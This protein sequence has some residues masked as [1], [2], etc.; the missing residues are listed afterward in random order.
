M[1]ALGVSPLVAYYFN[2]VSLISPVANLI[3]TPLVGFLLVPLSLAG[4]FLYMLTGHFVLGPLVQL[5]SG[6][7]VFLVRAFADVPAASVAAGAFPVG[8][9][10]VFYTGFAL[11]WYG[12]KKYFIALAIVP[13]ALYVAVNVASPRPFAV[14]FLDVGEADASIVELPDNRV[15]VVDTG[16]TGYEVRDAL[17]YRGIRSIDALALT[18][19]H[20]DHSGGVGLLLEEFKVKELWDNGRL[21]YPAG[22]MEDI[23]HRRLVRGDVYRGPGYT[24]T[25]L[26]PYDGFYTA[27]GNKNTSINNDSMVLRIAGQEASFLFTGDI[28]A[29][30]LEDLRHLGAHLGSDVLKVS[31][32]GRE[33]SSHSV[34]FRAVSPRIAVISGI[35]AGSEIAGALGGMTIVPTGAHGA[36]KITAHDGIT[37]KAYSESLLK[38]TLDPREEARNIKRL[39]TVW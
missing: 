24:I 12:R 32:H 15:L 10:L 36:V 14:T 7:A 28:E 33:S 6:V 38:K 31:H 11:Y 21:L 1:A 5:V 20:K 22:A 18:H 3:V 37:V 2:Y 4:S 35:R 26:H 29:E 25:A 13:L 39:F 27:W 16:R 34:F 8:L 30:A 23:T 17:R 9:L 19:A